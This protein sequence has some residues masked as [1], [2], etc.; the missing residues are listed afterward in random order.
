[1]K[2]T[3]RALRLDRTIGGLVTSATMLLPLLAVAVRACAGG[4]HRDGLPLLIRIS[5]A[6]GR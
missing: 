1:V 6:H 4:T 2:Y 5:R 3:Y